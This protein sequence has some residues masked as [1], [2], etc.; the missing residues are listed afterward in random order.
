MV[1]VAS[2]DGDVAVVVVHENGISAYVVEF[3]V[4]YAAVL[5]TVVD[6][7]TSAVDGPV[8]TEQLLLVLHE[9]THSVLECESFQVDALYGRGFAAVELNEVFQADNLNM[10]I[11]DVHFRIRHVVN[12]AGQSVVIPFARFVQLFLDILYK[13]VNRVH[14]RR[15]VVLP[16]AFQLQ[17]SVF[18]YPFDFP[19]HVSPECR[20]HG[21][22]VTAFGMSPVGY[23]F[24]L[25]RVHFRVGL[26]VVVE[27]PRVVYVSALSG[28]C[29]GESCHLLLHVV[30]IQL[31]DDNA[32]RHFGYVDVARFTFPVQL[33]LLSA[34]DDCFSFVAGAVGHR[35]RIILA[36][37][38]GKPYGRRQVIYAIFEDDFYTGVASE[39]TG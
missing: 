2:A 31:V 34:A 25:E 39:S 13:T 33:D 9:C 29:V 8:R 38:V 36:V 37:I 27:H 19:V 35:S 23:T 4:L 24:R 32:G 5:G 12:L 7:G 17:G 11:V 22:Y 20:V 28:L 18:V 6:D 15:T 1:D 26:S 3:A 16:A 21:V 10:G 14:A 30:Y